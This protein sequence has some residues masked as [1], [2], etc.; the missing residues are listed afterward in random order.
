MIQGVA[1]LKELLFD[2]ESANIKKLDQRL[3]AAFDRVQSLEGL[4]ER[5][6]TERRNEA[7]IALPK[8]SEM[9]FAL[10]KLTTTRRSRGQ[11]RLWWCRRSRLSCARAKVNSS[12]FCTQPLAECKSLCSDGQ[13]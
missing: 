6:R 13:E 3:N 10:R 9:R 2:T 1:W 4:N 12:R 7:E 11:L 8:S 5:E